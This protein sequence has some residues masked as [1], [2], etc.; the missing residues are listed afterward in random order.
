MVASEPVKGRI[1]I[2]WIAPTLSNGDILHYKINYTVLNSEGLPGPYTSNRTTASETLFT[3]YNMKTGIYLFTVTSQNVNGYGVPSTIQYQAAGIGPSNPSSPSTPS[4]PS[5]PS[6]PNS[7][8]NLAADAIEQTSIQLSWVAD[9]N[10]SE[11][12]IIQHKLLASTDPYQ[13]T[14]DL[15][16]PTIRSYTV[17]SLEPGTSYVFQIVALS[18]NMLSLPSNQVDVTTPHPTLKPF[19]QEIWFIAVVSSIACVIVIAMIVLVWL[20]KRHTN[21][22]TKAKRNE[23]YYML[24]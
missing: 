7:P 18:G 11:G 14:T 23:P 21:T 16:A 5:T 22:G 4:T 1:V 9:D 19:Y 13:N 12:F 2:R 17:T 10:P 6:I 15:L 3:F 8:T 24:G 20:R